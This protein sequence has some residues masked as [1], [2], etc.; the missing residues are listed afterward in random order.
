MWPSLNNPRRCTQNRFSKIAVL[1]DCVLR[2]HTVGKKKPPGRF[3]ASGGGNR[4]HVL[5][6]PHA[7]IA[8]RMT[9][10]ATRVEQLRAVHETHS[11]ARKRFAQWVGEHTVCGVF[12]NRGISHCAKPTTRLRERRKGRRS[13]E[14]F[15]RV[16]KRDKLPFVDDAPIGVSQQIGQPPVREP[17]VHADPPQQLVILMQGRRVECQILQR[18]RPHRPARPLGLF[19]MQ[20]G[21]FEPVDQL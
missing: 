10:R 6:R 18:T 1:I 15:R 5:V 11:E 9:A 14:A 17:A 19:T 4:V 13:N 12:G 2:C 3:A 16:T 8:R 20:I 7:G 21:A